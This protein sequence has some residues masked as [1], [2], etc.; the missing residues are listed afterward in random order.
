MLCV[1]LLTVSCSKSSVQL[2]KDGDPKV[3]A[4]SDVTTQVF[5]IIKDHASFPQNN[6]FVKNY[7]KLT[8]QWIS[9]VDFS[10][11]QITS[12]SVDAPNEQITC[13][14][15]IHLDASGIGQKDV[16]VDYVVKADLSR[17]QPIVEADLSN[18]SYPL[19]GFLDEIGSPDLEKAKK[20]TIRKNIARADS[21]ELEWASSHGDASKL[22]HDDIDKQVKGN[23]FSTDEKEMAFRIEVFEKIC[24]D[25]DDE[26]SALSCNRRNSLLEE[27]SKSN[28]LHLCYPEFTRWRHCDGTDIEDAPLSTATPPAGS[29]DAMSVNTASPANNSDAFTPEENKIID[30]EEY[31]NDKCRGGAGDQTEAFCAKRDDLFNQMKKINI[32]WGPDDVAESEHHWLRCHPK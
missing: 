2:L 29:I 7:E 26:N 8:Q 25:K 13:N 11:N 28:S 6:G 5:E 27:A 24:E 14:A 23:H 15:I 32:C 21:Y 20:D 12:K 19:S 31:L 18:I 3:C 9:K 30:Q 16:S 4:K 22:I 10:I 17:G 1:A